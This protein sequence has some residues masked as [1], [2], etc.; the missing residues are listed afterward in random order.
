MIPL[1]QF[2]C[3]TAY[4]PCPGSAAIQ[5]LLCRFLPAG[6]AVLVTR[7]PRELWSAACAQAGAH[8]VGCTAYVH[9]IRKE[10]IR[11]DARNCVRE[12]CTIATVSH[13]TGHHCSGTNPCNIHDCPRVH[14]SFAFLLHC[15][16]GNTLFPSAQPEETRHP[17]KRSKQ[18]HVCPRLC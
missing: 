15:N 2:W 5:A 1:S 14:A 12:G 4:P 6:E 10:T 16:I 18:I 11:R 17:T 13:V 3:T 7:D 9:Q 8:Y